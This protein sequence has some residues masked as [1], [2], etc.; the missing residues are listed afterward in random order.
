MAAYLAISKRLTK[1]PPPRGQTPQKDAMLMLYLKQEA[2][3]RS[4]TAK[5]QAGSYRTKYAF[6]N[7]L[8]T[9]CMVGKL[10]SLYPDSEL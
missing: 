4:Q 7:P 6:Q 5:S 3:E 2:F 8:L 1:R 10:D 9:A